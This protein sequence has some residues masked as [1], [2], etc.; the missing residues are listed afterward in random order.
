MGES[1]AAKYERGVFKPLQPV[2]YAEG[3]EVVLSVEIPALAPAQAKAQL[4]Q[5]GEVY[6]GLDSEKIAEIERLA[7]DRSHFLADRRGL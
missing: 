5:W 4:N 1:I 3:Q 6:A 7:V 2:E